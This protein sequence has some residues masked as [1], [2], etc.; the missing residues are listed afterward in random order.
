VYWPRLE[1]AFRGLLLELP[2]DVSENSAGSL[3]Y[4]KHALPVWSDAVRGAVHAAFG[5]ITQGLDSSAKNLK[6]VANAE[7]VLAM[8]LVKVMGKR[9]SVE[10]KGAM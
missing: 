2:H 10:E 5:S 9:E 4:G 1:E 8:E 7:R 6:A 3:E